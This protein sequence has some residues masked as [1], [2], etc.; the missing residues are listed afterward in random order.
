M[1]GLEESPRASAANADSMLSGGVRW[2]PNNA[3]ST[4]SENAILR[5]GDEPDVWLIVS[6]RVWLMGFV[7]DRQASCSFADIDRL[8]ADD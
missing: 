2:R 3:V 7:Y 8:L 1:A 5:V 4:A 6:V